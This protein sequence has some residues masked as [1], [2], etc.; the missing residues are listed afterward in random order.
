MDIG[1][2]MMETIIVITTFGNN[3]YILWKSFLFVHEPLE[4]QK[5]VTSTCNW[6]FIYHFKVYQVQL[7]TCGYI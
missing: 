4:S 2:E 7:A 3:L 5:L 1:V 6:H